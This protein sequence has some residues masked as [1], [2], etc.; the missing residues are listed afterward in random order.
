MKK[1]FRCEY[2]DKTGIE[3]E[4]LKHEDNC[5]YNHTKR[6]CMTCKHVENIITRFNCKAGKDIPEGKQ[7]VDC[8]K[9]EWDGVDHAHVTPNVFGNIFGGLF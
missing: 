4:I 2:C 1:I 7:F 5:I 6:S 9:Y 3:E 8:D